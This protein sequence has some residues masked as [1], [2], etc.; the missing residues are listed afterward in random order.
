MRDEHL[1]AGGGGNSLKNLQTCL[2]GVVF[3]FTALPGCNQGSQSPAAPTLPGVPQVAGT[4]TGSL[5][6]SAPAL[7]AQALTGSARMVVVQ[8]GSQLTITGSVTFLGETAALPAITGTVN[9][10]GF[11]TATAGGVTGSVADETCGAIRPTAGTITFSGRTMEIYE[12][13]TTDFCGS[14]QITG[15]LRR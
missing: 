15:N 13:A 9:S 3:A 14:F 6:F 5:S 8:S 1:R 10:T 2:I 11:F 4:Y 12:S 7:S